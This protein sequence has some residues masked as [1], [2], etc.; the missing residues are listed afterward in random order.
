M[1]VYDVYRRNDENRRECETKM[2]DSF[3]RGIINRNERKTRLAERSFLGF[4]VRRRIAVIVRRFIVKRRLPRGG[5][6]TLFRALRRVMHRTAAIFAATQGRRKGLF[7]I[8][9]RLLNKRT[10]HRRSKSLAKSTDSRKCGNQ[11]LPLDRRKPF[12][13][14]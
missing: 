3:N 5:K 7:N 1:S 2:F 9:E 4:S 8:L 12:M 13:L 10:F 14:V 6:I 11:Q